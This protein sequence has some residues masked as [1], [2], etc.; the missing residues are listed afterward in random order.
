MSRTF[1]LVLLFVAA[2]AAAAYYLRPETGYV[3]VSYGHWI[4]ETSLLGFFATA[5][6]ALLVS[7]GAARLFVAL[8]RL[9]ATIQETLAQRRQQRA[10]QSFESGLMKLLEGQWAAAEIEL[11]R[12]AADHPSPALNYLL[13]A[14]AAQRAGT[15]A[16]RDQYLELAARHGEG[17]GFATQL[18]RAELQLEQDTASAVPVL[19]E[20]RRRDPRHP[21]VIELL[22]RAYARAGSW[23]PLRQLLAGTDAARALPP[24]RY[25]SLFAR[26]LREGLAQATATARLDALKSLWESAPAEIRAAPEVRHAYVRGLARLGAETEAAAQIVQM[27]KAG[28]DAGLIAIYGE[29]GGLDP[30]TQLAAVEG[31]L[32]QQGE[33]PELLLAAGQVC[34]RN[35]LWGKARSYLDSALKQQPTP[36]VFLALAQLCEKIRQPEDAAL[37]HRRGLELAATDQPSLGQVS[38]A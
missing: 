37:F 32:T 26:A 12:R 30:M 11:V 8:L 1:A 15:S 23:E 18:L 9:P 28:W 21:Y 34:T 6:A 31:W 4:L 22:A 25:R 17:A 33:K 19:Q 38:K 2:G 29:L 24:A 13:A 35:Q 20:L 5:I 10:Q 16:R 36:A 7:Y 14:R 3:L 27:L